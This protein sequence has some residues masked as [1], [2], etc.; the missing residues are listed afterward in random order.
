M[1]RYLTAGTK[2]RFLALLQCIPSALQE[3]RNR[4]EIVPC[5]YATKAIFSHFWESLIPW[6]F[7]AAKKTTIPLYTWT[8]LVSGTSFLLA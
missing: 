7:A 5:P 4:Q 1:E 2:P 3:S 6:R 8:D